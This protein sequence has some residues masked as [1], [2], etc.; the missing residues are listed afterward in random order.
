M[1]KFKGKGSAQEEAYRIMEK[2]DLKENGLSMP[3]EQDTPQSP[4]SSPEQVLA[5]LE[6]TRERLLRTLAEMDN[7]KK[8]SKREMEDFRK[9]ANEDLI[10]GLLPVIDNLE[11]ALDS[12]RKGQ[13]DLGALVEGVDL[14]AKE[15]SNLLGK[16]GVTCVDA[17]GKPFD[18]AYHQA[19]MQQPSH[20]HPENTVMEEVQKG[21][22][23]KERLL[24]PSLVCVSAGS[25]KEGADEN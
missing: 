2:E 6:E 23:M 13:C 3:D 25:P 18:P 21:Y 15:I 16:Y 14:T 10:K 9:Y 7:F 8:R 4:Q 12:A 11:R 20:E 24:R 22:T 19:L 17:L 1:D 5:E